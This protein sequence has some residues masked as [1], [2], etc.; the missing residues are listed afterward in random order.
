MKICILICGLP[1]STELV[2]QNL[3]NLFKDHKIYL[4]IST[5]LINNIGVT[6]QKISVNNTVFE[7]KEYLN[8]TYDYKKYIN[9]NIEN[10]I[11]I[12]NEENTSYR[13]SLNYT[14]KISYGLK[15]IDKIYDMY[16]VLRSD[17]ILTN[18]DFINYITDESLY[19]SN[20]HNNKYT[21]SIINTVNEQIII[22]KNI[23]TLMQLVNIYDYTIENN[24]YIDIALYNYLKINKIQYKL[25]DIKYKLILSQCNVIAIS[26]DSG[27]GKSTLLKYLFK[28]FGKGNT[29][30]IETDRYHKWERGNVNYN[31][32]THLNP[33]ANHLEMMSNDVFNLKIGNE[34]YQID[35][36]H[37]TGKFTEKKKL[38]PNKNIILCGLHTL[39]NNKLNTIIDIKMFM[40]TDI[41]LLI[42]WKIKRDV[43]ERKHSIEYIL[44][45]VEKR[46]KDYYSYILNQKDNA[47]IIIQF[48]ENGSTEHMGGNLI[49]NTGELI[50]SNYITTT[51]VFD[52]LKYIDLSCNFIIN[53]KKISERLINYFIKYN[54]N[55]S[56]KD[57]NIIVQLKNNIQDIYNNENIKDF[58]L[59]D[60]DFNN[61]YYNEII[62]LLILYCYK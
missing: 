10:I 9:E 15:I 32:Y 36:D 6:D 26:G 47:D 3:K 27:S 60:N 23:D 51:N 30:T 57:D 43:V 54:Y 8:T 45:Q 22:S 29:L 33:Y 18:I 20:L 31:T 37:S 4:Y 61:V 1:R 17:N 34:I 62:I 7:E 13:N 58:F 44:N 11:F 40:D 38:E 41:N 49:N 39:Y 46:K 55:I 52:N 53:N 16:I 50:D 48:Y 24:N 2:I 12:K 21:K 5:S 25:L 59:L 28:L 56:S 35:Y 19:F 14:K 42:K